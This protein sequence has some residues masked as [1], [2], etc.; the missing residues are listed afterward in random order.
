MA[1]SHVLSQQSF[2]HSRIRSRARELGYDLTKVE[3]IYDGVV[4][5]DG[6]LKAPLK[7][8]WVLK[9]PYDDTDSSGNP[10]GG[11]WTMF[12]DFGAGKSL[13]SSVNANTALRNVA[14]ASWALLSGVSRYADI[15]WISD[16][17]EVAE[18]LLRV[19]YL[20][21]GKMPAAT[22]T[23]EARLRKIQGEWRDIVLDQMALADPDLIVFAGTLQVWAGEFGIDITKP[24]RSA[25][26][27]QGSTKSVCDVHQ[28]HG[29]RILWSDHPAVHKPPE[30]W[31]DSLLDAARL[32]L[33]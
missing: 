28:W 27:G 31:V 6:Y 19:C 23:S 12:K 14:Y 20:N 17:P 21:T 1:I 7:V 11:G 3:P 4:D 2:L 5:W 13:A 16:R 10:A 22:T 15:P 26:R 29:K 30:N 9:E 18:S 32:P 33:P 24:L 25:S 8:C